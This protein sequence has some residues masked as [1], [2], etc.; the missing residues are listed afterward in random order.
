MSRTLHFYNEGRKTIEI[1]DTDKKTLLYRVDTAHSKPHITVSRAFERGSKSVIPIGTVTNHRWSSK[2]DVQISGCPLIIMESGFMSSRYPINL[3]QLKGEWSDK[4]PMSA[5]LVFQTSKG[6][7]M[8]LFEHSRW[9]RNKEGKMH[10]EGGV[11]QAEL[12]AL[13]VTGVARIDEQ[14]RSRKNA[15]AG[16]AGG[17]P[18]GDAGGGPAGD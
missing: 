10:L 7:R 9:A 18:A 12:D 4:G 11:S 8:A 17:G 13:I 16:D 5:D 1:F 15:A 6:K 3:P 2:M 14:R